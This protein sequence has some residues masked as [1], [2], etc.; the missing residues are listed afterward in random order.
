MPCKIGSAGWSC[1]CATICALCS[2]IAAMAM[3]YVINVRFQTLG[4]RRGVRIH[5]YK[6]FS[7][8]YTLGS[9]QSAH[10]MCT[11]RELT[12]TPILGRL[13]IYFQQCLPV[14]Q[15]L[16]TKYN[17]TFKKPA[18]H[19]YTHHNNFNQNNATNLGHNE[20][21]EKLELITQIT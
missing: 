21:N 4:T 9:N 2:I 14:Y 19:D 17:V 18:H 1:R 10:G 16:G 13:P 12:G 15:G 3:K 8:R 20:R 7:E 5:A 6:A 11:L